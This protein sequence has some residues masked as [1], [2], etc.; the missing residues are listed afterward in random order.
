MKTRVTE[1]LGIRHPILM[2]AMHWVSNAEMVAAVAE[3]G[4]IGFLPA[5]T[6]ADAETMK[7]EIRKARA[8]TDGPIGVNISMLSTINPGEALFDLLETAI[9]EK[10]A[11]FETAG[12]L[13]VEI[14]P[15]IREAG[16]PLIHK[17][18]QARFAKKA[19]S[20][21]VDAVIVVGYECGGF[22]GMSDT[23]SMV[24]INRTARELSIPVIAGGG[25]V[26]GR[27]LVAALALGAEAVLMGT[28]FLASTEAPLHENW[29]KR[30]LEISE[31]DTAV[32]MKSV[33]NSAR[34]IRNATTAKIQEIESRGGTLEEL[35]SALEGNFG[36]TVYEKGNVEY[37]I[38]SAG[39]GIGLIQD[40]KSIG[41][42]IRD[43]VE[44]AE[45]TISRLRRISAS[46]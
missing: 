19:E 20:I 21:G 6:F 36:K 24:L 33:G 4:G 34:M 3:A 25:I 43:I 22:T 31:T 35:M 45:V 38:A 27:G 8:L 14:A 13:P 9:E 40:I 41:V 11:A 46:A 29:K 16:I 32:L 28:R 37:G 26:D 10:V 42:I 39:E 15:R 2:G 7:S 17:V 1:L 18:P 5:A 12:R 30:F 44:E 23:T